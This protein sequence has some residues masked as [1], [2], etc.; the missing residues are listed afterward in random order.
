MFGKALGDP[1]DLLDQAATIYFLFG[2]TPV[3]AIVAALWAYIQIVLPDITFSHGGRGMEPSDEAKLTFYHEF[4]HASHFANVGDRFWLSLVDAEIDAGGHGDAN[5]PDALLIA[6][7][8]SW[9]EHVG[10]TYAHRTYGAAASTLPTSTLLEILEHTRNESPN[11]EPIG[12]YHDLV[13]NFP[14]AFDA[15]D[16]EGGGC[17]PI[18]DQASGFTQAQMFGLLDAATTSPMIFRDRLI[19]GTS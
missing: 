3:G 18:D 4:S 9:A 6:I 8:E 17:G 12:F 5:G 11:H 13:D 15:C 7:V 14:D 1:W 2:A 10:L 19:Q 16:Q